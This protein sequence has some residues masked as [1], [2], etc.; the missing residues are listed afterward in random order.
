MPDLAPLDLAYF[1]QSILDRVKPTD[2][3]QRMI[4]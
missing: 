4:W 1:Q 3:T 2:V